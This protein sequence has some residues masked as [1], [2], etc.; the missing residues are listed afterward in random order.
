MIVTPR[1]EPVVL[2]ACDSMPTWSGGPYSGT[3]SWVPQRNM[4]QRA[5]K[6]LYKHVVV[7]RD[8]A[9]GV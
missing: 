5:C 3:G 4:V 1:A 8:V 6:E 2:G 9:G 7:A